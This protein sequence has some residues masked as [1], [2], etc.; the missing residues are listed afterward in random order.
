MALGKL[1]F[2][3]G[4]HTC[5]SL[6]LPAPI[7]GFVTRLFCGSCFGFSWSLKYLSKPE[8]VY[9]G[10]ASTHSGGERPPVCPCGAVA[11]VLSA[12]VTDPLALELGRYH[13]FVHVG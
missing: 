11:L 12:R 8:H 6:L 4:T 9:A 13:Q 10:V 2:N 3:S 1:E 7:D 5:A